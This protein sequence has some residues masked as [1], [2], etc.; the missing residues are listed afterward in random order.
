MILHP[1][2]L[3]F[4]SPFVNTAALASYISLVNKYAMTHESTKAVK[5]HPLTPAIVS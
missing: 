4:N 1:A 5:A 3:K 2:G